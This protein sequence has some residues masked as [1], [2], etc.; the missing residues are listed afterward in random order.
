VGGRPRR[1]P[2]ARSLQ[3]HDRRLAERVPPKATK[4]AA[5][6]IAVGQIWR[7]GS[8]RLRVLAYSKNPMKHDADDGKSTHVVG[9]RFIDPSGR[10]TGRMIR[11]RTPAYQTYPEQQF[12]E[13]FRFVSGPAEDA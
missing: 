10:E 8:R 1:H 7:F 5:V 9:C 12:R 6:E 2:D 4:D 3:R 11:S 13:K